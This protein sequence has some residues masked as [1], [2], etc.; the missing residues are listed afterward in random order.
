ML[1]FNLTNTDGLAEL[2]IRKTLQDRKQGAVEHRHHANTSSDMPRTTSAG[3][4]D[5]THPS[6]VAHD[7]SDVENSWERHNTARACVTVA[8]GSMSAG[9][10]QGLEEIIRV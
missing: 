4:R 10:V 5:T 9:E 6:Q 1:M 7:A 2:K 3:E 8:R